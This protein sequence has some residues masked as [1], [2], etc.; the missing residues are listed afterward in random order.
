MQQGG[1]IH[2]LL[3]LLADEVHGVGLCPKIRLVATKEHWHTG[4][5]QQRHRQ[6]IKEV[7]AV[8]GPQHECPRAVWTRC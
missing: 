8:S 7:P 6:D 5:G 2:F 3:Q 4:L 1:R